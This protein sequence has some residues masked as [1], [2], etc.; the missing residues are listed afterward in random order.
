MSCLCVLPMSTNP[1]VG[2]YYDIKYT[3]SAMYEYNGNFSVHKI[4]CKIFTGVQ[5]EVFS[6]KFGA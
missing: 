6:L 4:K 5:D 3:P 2:N 1:D